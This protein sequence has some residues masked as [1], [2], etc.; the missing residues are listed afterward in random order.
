MTKMYLEICREVELKKVMMPKRPLE[1]FCDAKVRI[2][3]NMSK[4]SAKKAVFL[5]SQSQKTWKLTVKK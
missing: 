2:F 1:L 5:Q 4:K 3:D